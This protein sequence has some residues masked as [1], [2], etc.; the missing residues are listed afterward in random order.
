MSTI[1]KITPNLWFD[2]QAEE[3]ARF[4]VSVF[5]DAEIRRVSHYGPNASMP[6][7]TALTVEFTLE[8]QTFTALNGGPQFSFTPAI[9]FLV[10]CET[11]VEVDHYWDR[12]SEGGDPEAQMCGWLKDKYGVSWQIVPEA[13]GRFMTDPDRTKAGRTMQAMLKM[14]KLDIEG[15]RRAHD[16]EEEA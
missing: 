12:L 4:Y 10:T 5:R 6:E 1:Q 11:Q 3:A 15:L 2:G 8:G 13:L 7:G 9:S 16:G 14:K